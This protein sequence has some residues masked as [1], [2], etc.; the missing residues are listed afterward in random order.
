[1]EIQEL[2]ID[3][4]MKNRVEV[5]KEIRLSITM[6]RYRLVFQMILDDLYLIRFRY[7]IIA[8]DGFQSNG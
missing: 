8:Y 5:R 6:V 1:M 7:M 3:K 2:I 4:G